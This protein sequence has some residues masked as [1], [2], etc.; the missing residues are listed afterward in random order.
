MVHIEDQFQVEVSKLNLALGLMRSAIQK[1]IHQVEVA[2]QAIMK[3][4]TEN[5]KDIEKWARII[6]EEH[7]IE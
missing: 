2:K 6:E 7:G 3:E 4:K 5:E 1:A